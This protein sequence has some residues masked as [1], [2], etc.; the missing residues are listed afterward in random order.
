MIAWGRGGDG[1][2]LMPRPGPTREVGA[3]M[4]EPGLPT[5]LGQGGGAGV[6]WGWE[7]L[8]AGFYRE[9]LLAGFPPPPIELFFH[10]LLITFEL[11]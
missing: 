7:N 11:Y 6:V 5:G 4:D 2:G 1:G 8:L 10:L 9:N 3:G